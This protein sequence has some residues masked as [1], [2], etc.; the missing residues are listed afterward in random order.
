MSA[1]L[2]QEFIE[3]SAR[4]LNEVLGGYSALSQ[5]SAEF[6]KSLTS[7][8]GGLQK[9]AGIGARAFAFGTGTIA[10][11]IAVADPVRWE[12]LGYAIKDASAV[13]G[14]Q[15]APVVD[16]VIEGIYKVAGAILNMDPATRKQIVT[17]V[18]WGVGIGGVAMILPRLIAPIGMIVGGVRML[19]GAMI[20]LNAGSGG[21]IVA[22]GL[23][24]SLFAGLYASAKG[25]DTS[26]GGIAGTLTRAGQSIAPVVESI[27][28][29]FVA[30]EPVILEF[31][32]VVKDTMVP[33][34]NKAVTAIRATADALKDIEGK[35]NSISNVGGGGGSGGG[36]SMI[37]AAFPMLT[38]LRNPGSLG[39]GGILGSLIPENQTSRVESAKQKSPVGMGGGPGGFGDVTSGWRKAMEASMKGPMEE[40]V[41]EL[42]QIRELIEQSAYNDSSWQGNSNGDW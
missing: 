38:F 35:I 1:P 31:G 40:A 16:K 23:V 17:W 34:L 39:L 7:V 36:F 18:T 37:E 19:T 6:G 30:L 28:D 15:F 13:I 2:V 41:D 26:V 42:Q 22:L 21:I 29:M 33:I 14:Q 8:Q 4:G 5:R 24:V 9:V 25:A 20:A 3:F 10:G 27:K 11:M 32:N 12:R